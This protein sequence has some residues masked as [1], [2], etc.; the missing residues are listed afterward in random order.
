MRPRTTCT[1][2]FRAC[3]RTRPTSSHPP[4]KARC[5]LTDTD[6]QGLIDLVDWRRRVGDL[7][8]IGGPDAVS[9]FRRG[10]D[11]LFR[12]HPQSPIEPDERGYFAG[13]HYFPHAP[14]YRLDARFE[15][16]DGSERL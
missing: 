3:R 5:Q 2:S 9:R 6:A 12:A 14:T 10:R 15:P 7:Y 4:T 11:E 1:R 13:L 16:G 8:R